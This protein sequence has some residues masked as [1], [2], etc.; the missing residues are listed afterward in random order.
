MQTQKLIFEQWLSDFSRAYETSFHRMSIDAAKEFIVITIKDYGYNVE[1]KSDTHVYGHPAILNIPDEPYI[2]NYDV[3]SIV[4]NY[5]ASKKRKL[6]GE[7]QSPRYC[8]IYADALSKI[9]SINLSVIVNSML[10][11]GLSVEDMVE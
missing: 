9:S 2:S 11:S 10:E 8:R 3:C 4:A 6:F 1:L 7:M 5:V